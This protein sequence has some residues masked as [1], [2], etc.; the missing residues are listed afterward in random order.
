ML[1]N[2]YKFAICRNIKI[3]YFVNMKSKYEIDM[4]NGS[5]FPKIILF[6]LPLILSGILQLAFNAADLIV[7]GQ[8]SSDAS[9]LAAIGDTSSLINFF[10]NVIVGVSVGSNV[11]VARYIGAGKDKDVHDA[12]H[13]SIA[14][15]LL[16]GVIV[17]ILGIIFSRPILAAMDTP[18]NV[19]DL[20]VLYINIYFIGLPTS[21]VYNFGSAILR[22][23]GDTKR[24]LIYLTISGVVNV[25][26]NLLFVIGLGMTVEGVA[27]ATI[28]SQALSAV[29]VARCLMK[30]DASYK[31]ILKDLR[32]NFGILKK[33][34]QIG[35]PAGVQGMIFSLS[36]I[37]IQSSVNFFG[38]TAMAGNT[39]C[40]SLEGFV[41]T[42]MNA[43][44]QTTLSFTSQNYGAGKLKRI[45]KIL[46]EC[47]ILV[48]IVG[49]VLGNGVYIFG[50]FFLSLYRSE[51]DVIAMGMV[52][53]SVICTLYC[54]CGLME[55]FCGVLRGLGYGIMPMIVSLIGACGFR[56]F[57]IYT[58]FQQHH[59]LRVLYWSYPISW[60]L[61]ITAHAICLLIVWN[62]KVKKIRST[63]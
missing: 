18:D 47:I 55:V 43:V 22:S 30:T 39:A 3:M 9:A 34:L 16:L 4:T 29:L 56:I 13:T 49:L 11:V 50:H 31:L 45:K 60:I 2:M 7:V 52:R 10:I 38:D 42:S 61:T 59:T 26:L 21:M 63:D 28:I 1:E 51:E 24:P 40:Q 20:S 5:L 53:L 58:I 25:L 46:L 33:I 36:N 17:G 48:T 44:Y 54:T 6:S 37:L 62:T 14:V 8:Y 19:I 15:C 27:L 41:Y 12:V 32:I 23:A 35:L 57:W